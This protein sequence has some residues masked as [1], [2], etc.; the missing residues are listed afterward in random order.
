MGGRNRNK[1]YNKIG[2]AWKHEIGR[3]NKHKYYSRPKKTG[4]RF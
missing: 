1:I 4:Y 3:N 2:K